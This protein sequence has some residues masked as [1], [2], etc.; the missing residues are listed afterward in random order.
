[1]ID[2]G[3]SNIG[4]FGETDWFSGV[5]LSAVQC[6]F[7]GGVLV[8]SSVGEAAVFFREGQ[9]VHAAGSGFSSGYLGS[10]LVEMSACTQADVDAAVAVQDSEAQPRPIGAILV[11][12]AN[13]NPADVKRAI[14]KQNEQRFAQIFGWPD[15]SWQAAPGDN[16]RIRE[17]GVAT[18]A[19]PTFFRALEATLTDAELRG[20][21]SRLLG[22]AVQLRGG[23]LGISEYDPTR[24]ERKM[25][26]YLEK[27]RKP[28]HL[29]RA[30]KK[31][32]A[33]R[34]FLRGL[35]L[36]ERLK[37]V[38]VAKAVPIPKVT[39]TTLDLPGAEAAQAIVK[40]RATSDVQRTA[41]P[42]APKPTPKTSTAPIVKEVQALYDQLDDKNYF[43]L[44]GAGDKTTH[45]ELRKLFTALAK[46]YHPDALPSDVDEKTAKKAE[47]ISATLNQAYRTLSHEKERADYL[48]I[49][50]DVRIKGDFKRVEKVREA[51][52]KAKMGGV[53][54]NKRE[55]R[56]ARDFFKRARELD[57]ATPE[58]TA[59]F[60]WAT[61]ADPNRDRAAALEEALPLIR[62]ALAGDGKNPTIHYYMGQ[63]LKTQGD[64]KN[65]LHHFKQAL[66]LDAKHTDAER[67]V[68]L[69]E[70]RQNKQK[71]DG[72]SGSSRLSRLFK[73]S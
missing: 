58:Y 57:P 69:L 8:K 59:Q 6:K 24:L 31:R 34:G 20:I 2:L 12:N 9:P 67:E 60:G 45:A 17:L 7:T 53:M 73:R 38:S 4:T 28:D 32:K 65:A 72:D 30:L 50:S 56:Q 70:L 33:V 52:M 36:L 46:K 29:E 26:S 15:G 23:H 48:L 47:T 21:A 37:V 44:L 14:Q 41:K 63:I 19:W 55:F 39:L 51:E 27:P 66:R 71:S 49:L 3:V 62:D 40:A 11:A 13:T 22:R 43:E 61:F 64:T 42:A 1:M 5:Y 68:R 54:L 10:L 18:A 16:T 25:L 35:E